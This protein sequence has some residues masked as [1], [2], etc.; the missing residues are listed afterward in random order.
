MS[1]FKLSRD[2]SRDFA[3][4][5]LRIRNVDEFYQLLKTGDF[6]AVN[7]AGGWFI[8]V[9]SNRD[10]FHDLNVNWDEFK[11]NGRQA[12]DQAVRQCEVFPNPPF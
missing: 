3:H 5:T 7:R 2:V 11:S 4:K 1:M 10:H 6:D 9:N 8:H 12:L